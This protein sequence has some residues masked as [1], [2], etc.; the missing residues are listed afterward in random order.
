M[1]VGYFPY[2]LG[3]D[4]RSNNIYKLGRNNNDSFAKTWQDPFVVMKVFMKS[5]L[6]SNM[7]FDDAS[8]STSWSLL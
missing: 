3:A 4:S 8:C 6:D 5:H 2:S 1:L 7:G